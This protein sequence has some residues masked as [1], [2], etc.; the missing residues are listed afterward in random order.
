MPTSEPRRT[1]QRPRVNMQEV[2]DRAGVALSSVSRVLSNHPDVSAK[3]RQAVEEAVNELSYRPDMLAQGL[4][5][6]ETHSVGVTVSDLSNPVLAQ[7]VN[8]AEQYLRGAGYSLLLTDAGGDAEMDAT[9]LELLEQR[10]VDGVLLAVSD[11]HNP[12]TVRVLQSIDVPLVLVDRDRP[13]GVDALQIAFDHQRGMRAATE[14]LLEL[15]HRDIALIIG[16]PRR[17]ARERRLAVEETAAAAGA[18]VSVL[19]GPFTIEHGRI[20]TNEVLV[21]KQRP[22]A[23]IAGGNLLMHGALRA[24]RNAGVRVGRDLSFVGCDDVAV[25][26][27]HDPP[28]ALV[29]RDTRLMGER[30]A[31]LLLAALAGERSDETE[32]LPTEYVATESCA[33]PP[34]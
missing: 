3:M 18:V 25:A 2:A 9:G 32:V 5:R 15:G 23:L 24:L 6:R 14:H 34:R 19:E 20:A 12:A 21:R 7:I 27:F 28:L 4:R 13:E 1:V 26:E 16:G 29:R 31:A 30:A 8:G 11:E 22:T 10:R 17:P 33:K